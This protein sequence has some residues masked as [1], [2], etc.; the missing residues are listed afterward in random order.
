MGRSGCRA[1][2]LTSGVHP[3]P[4]FQAMGSTEVR[5]MWSKPLAPNIPSAPKKLC[6]FEPFIGGTSF[7][8]EAV[9]TSGRYG[10]LQYEYLKN[11][12]ISTSTLCISCYTSLSAREYDPH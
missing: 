1:L 12:H 8:R 11:Y 2:A 7:F 5:D 6:V 4:I 9:A 10:Y 3:M